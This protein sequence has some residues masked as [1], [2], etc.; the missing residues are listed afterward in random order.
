MA[1]ENKKKTTDDETNANGNPEAHGSPAADPA[2][3]SQCSHHD[4][5]LHTEHNDERAPTSRKLI[6]FYQEYVSGL[7]MGPSCR[8]EPTCSDYALTALARHG[9]VKGLLLS[10]GRL[11]R[12]APWHPG[13][14]DPVPP[15]KKR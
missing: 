13:G 3:S 11:L 6:N 10:M 9:L 15:V 7:K 5:E 4:D 1:F 8:F 14:W 2:R 12:C